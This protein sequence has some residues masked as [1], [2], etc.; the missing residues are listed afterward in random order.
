MA[1]NRGVYVPREAWNWLM[2]L[3]GDFEPSTNVMRLS[4]GNP[5]RYWWRSELRRRID[6]AR[7]RK[8]RASSSTRGYSK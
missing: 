6:R 4:N 7:K 8:A 3:G 2:G 1:S 5:G